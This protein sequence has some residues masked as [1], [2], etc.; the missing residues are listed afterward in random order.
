[1]AFKTSGR[2]EVCWQVLDASTTRVL[3]CAM[4]DASGPG[5]ELRVGHF[6]DP[7]LRSQMMPDIASARELAQRW[8]DAARAEAKGSEG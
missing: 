7:P 5:V 6:G 4:F 8:L 1:M 3:R 2:L